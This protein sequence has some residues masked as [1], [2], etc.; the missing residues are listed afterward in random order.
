[1]LTPPSF[2]SVD[3]AYYVA[4]QGPLAV[5]ATPAATDEFG[6]TYRIDTQQVVTVLPLTSGIIAQLSNQLPLPQF[7]VR[8][9]DFFCVRDFQIWESLSHGHLLR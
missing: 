6:I 4:S 9:L 5:S 2:V 8:L 3:M 7:E 1:M